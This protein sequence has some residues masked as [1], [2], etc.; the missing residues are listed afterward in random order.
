MSL[1]SAE[2]PISTPKLVQS[3]KD[4]PTGSGW[5]KHYAAS[6]ELL[7]KKVGPNVFNGGS[8]YFIDLRDNNKAIE[9]EVSMDPQDPNAERIK[10]SFLG[11]GKGEE[12]DDGLHL[13]I[14]RTSQANFKKGIKAPTTEF[15]LYDTMRNTFIPLSP[16]NLYTRPNKE[17]I[18]GETPIMAI[19][20]TTY[21]GEES[22]K[23]NHNGVILWFPHSF[24]ISDAILADPKGR[25]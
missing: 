12:I 2:T 3:L 5:L 14:M 13:Q 11:K 22:K 21:S 1:S 18:G 17:E 23:S 8:M 24:Y 20:G 7:R 15:I 25:E 4:V 19:I 9:M 6:T 10:Q 16:G